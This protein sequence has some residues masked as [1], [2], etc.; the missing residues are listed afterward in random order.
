MLFRCWKQRSVININN[1]LEFTPIELPLRQQMGAETPTEQR[2][3][4]QK[5]DSIFTLNPAA[6]FSLK[7]PGEK[8]FRDDTIQLDRLITPHPYHQFLTHTNR[9]GQAGRTVPPALRACKHFRE[10]SGKK[11]QGKKFEISQCQG[12]RRGK[13]KHG[14]LHTN[15]RTS[16]LC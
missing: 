14:W 2:V 5:Q 7:G 16:Q 9:P 1:K 3:R 8:L 15:T 13:I 4:M 6:L 10:R 12:A 11:R